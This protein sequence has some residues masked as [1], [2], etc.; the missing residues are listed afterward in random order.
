M[1]ERK[2]QNKKGFPIV[3]KTIVNAAA[4]KTEEKYEGN[5]LYYVANFPT[6]CQLV[7]LSVYLYS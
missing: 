5:K 7:K 3:K 2:T 4:T 1:P 6:L